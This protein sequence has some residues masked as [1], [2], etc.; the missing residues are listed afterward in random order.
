MKKKKQSE[1]S[2]DSGEIFPVD[3]LGIP[4]LVDVVEPSELP[5]LDQEPENLATNAENETGALDIRTASERE[6]SNESPADIHLDQI[7]ERIANLVTDEIMQAL[8]PL[9]RD[10]V[11]LALQ[12]YENELLQLPDD[13][14]ETK[15][16]V[17]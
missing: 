15:P 10:K 7:T 16:K 17:N 8:E 12:L 11:N 4:I 6:S 3:M 5:N 13:E 9:V 1:N 14:S 2:F